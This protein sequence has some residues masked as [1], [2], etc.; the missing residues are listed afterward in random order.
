MPKVRTEGNLDQLH[1]KIVITL[2]KTDAEADEPVNVKAAATRAKKGKL[3]FYQRILES[4]P[5]QTVSSLGMAGSVA[6]T[7]AAIAQADV[8]KNETEL[9]VANL[10]V[11]HMAGAFEFPPF[12]SD[13][14]DHVSFGNWGQNVIESKIAEA[15]EFIE[16]TSESRIDETSE[17]ASDQVSEEVENEEAQQEEASDAETDEQ[18]SETSAEESDDVADDRIAESVTDQDVTAEDVIDDAEASEENDDVVH[19][20]DV[21]ESADE[22]NQSNTE[23]PKVITPNNATPVSPNGY[24]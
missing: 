5:A 16:Q 8:A 10:A 15:R 7:T 23:L 3:S 11:D 24:V 20:Q 21:D 17:D 6:L 9:L 13:R 18:N 19:S 2:G 1:G 12:L 4:A 22:V 14:I